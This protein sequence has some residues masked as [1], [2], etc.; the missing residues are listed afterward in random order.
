M[1]ADL[2]QVK[3]RLMAA[4]I[5]SSAVCPL[6]CKYCYIPKTPSMKNLQEKIIEK[7]K[8][9]TFIDDL[10]KFYGDRLEHLAMWGAEPTL[11]LNYIGDAVPDLIKK[12]PKLKSFSLSTSLMTDPDVIVNFAKTLSKIDRKVDF[13]CQI[14]LD[15]PAY[16]TDI[17]RIVGAAKKA[18]E[19]LYY[20][21]K[22]FNKIS[23]NNL[24]ANFHIKSTLT[25]NNI[26]YLNKNKKKIK[27]YFDYFESIYLNQK[28]INKNKNVSF[29]CSS[30]PTLTVPGKYVSGDGKELALFFKN[31]RELARENKEKHYW[32]HIQGSLNAYTYRLAR[33]FKSQ[34][35]LTSK[36]FIFTCSGGDSDFGLGV[37]NDIRICHRMF[38]L[39]N[40]EYINGILSKENIENW[41]VS[42]LNRGNLDLIN[43]KY[44]MN[45]KNEK[46]WSRVLYILRNYHDFTQMRNAYITAIVRELALCGQADKKYLTSESLRYLLAVFLNSA[47]ACHTENILNTGV[48]YFNP[49][50]VIRLFSNG[51]FT[52]ILKDFHENF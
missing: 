46:G 22:K 25:P 51:A 21:T 42:L 35:E 30:I 8:N 18:P 4:E 33:L 6:D 3:R 50:S 20:I 1:K 14:S 11:T 38:F 29:N 19:N 44:S 2:P 26:K 32:T 12:F 41:D 36:S 48:I 40:E 45:T 15:G 31:L 10:E 37:N 16:I 39:N 5:F 34:D 47:L 52:E 27:E 9:K 17:N 28:K 24:K 49:V 23:L 13:K 7:L 43:E